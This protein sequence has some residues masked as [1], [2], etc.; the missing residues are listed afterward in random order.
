MASKRPRVA[1][2]VVSSQTAYVSSRFPRPDHR[3][4]LIA[5]PRRHALRS[6]LLSDL[7]SGALSRGID[8]SRPRG[9]LQPHS[10]CGPAR[11][12]VPR[13]EENQAASHMWTPAT[14]RRTWRP[15]LTS[16]C[17]PGDPQTT[18]RMGDATAR[19]ARAVEVA[20]RVRRATRPAEA[21][22]RRYYA[23]QREI[24]QRAC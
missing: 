23:F 11:P 15:M 1:S 12:E 9:G 20:S 19:K 6:T 5:Y 21:L 4:P 14:Q 13:A 16:F 18:R 8:P 2:A 17:V 7:R 22:R 3:F 10:R 24:A